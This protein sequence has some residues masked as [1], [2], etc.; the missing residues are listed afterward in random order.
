M[1]RDGTE[2]GYELELTRAVADA[3]DVPVIASGGAGTL[4][5]LVEAV[6]EGG[7]DAVLCASIFHYGQH[8]RARGQ[9][10][11]ARGRHPGAA[12]TRADAAR[13]T[14]LRERIRRLPGMDRL[15][16]ALEGLPPTY[17]VGGAVRDLLRGR[18]RRRPRPRRGGR[19]PLGRRARWPSASAARRASTSASA[20]RPCAP[21]SSA[22]TSPPRAP[23][24]TTSPARCRAWRPPRSPRTC[25]R[26]DFTVNAMA[27]APAGRRP[28]PPVR[29]ARRARATSRRAWCAILHPGSFLDDPTRL[30]RAVRYE[31]RLGFRMDED[32]ERAARAAV[33]EDAMS[34]VS[35]ARVR[36]RADGP[37]RRARGARGGRAPARP[38]SRPRAAPGARP[39]PGAGRLRVARRGGDRRRPRPR[40]AG[41]AVRGRA[42][43]A[44]TVAG[45]PPARRAARATRSRAR[46]ACAPRAGGG[47]A[48][49]ASACP[50]SCAT[51]SAASRPR[52][53][54]WRWRWA[55][56]PSRS[57]AGRP[58]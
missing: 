35:G 14:D 20:P 56:R 4:D 36:R 49:R 5:H 24:P 43:G 46:R 10:A 42:G 15:L 30:L 50:R 2:D 55:R 29:P 38:R 40:L 48:R 19:R 33:A 17:L 58:T 47:A 21:A 22:S 9:G 28:R 31:T 16:P 26:R 13:H 12:L 45:G 1:D 37:A 7:A 53:W 8:T 51:C 41:G 23:R 27:V 39:G 32:T 54:R 6:N 44:A 57:C 3:V 34:T 52:R 11:H 25:G 18:G